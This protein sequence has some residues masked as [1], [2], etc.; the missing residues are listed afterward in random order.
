MAVNVPILQEE[1]NRISKKIIEMCKPEKIIMFGSLA[2]GNAEEYSDIDLAVVMDTDL[3][4]V[5]RIL[6]LVELTD[7]QVPVDFMVYTPK[8]FQQ[9][10][11]E[12]NL[13][14][15]EEVLKK[16]VILYDRNFS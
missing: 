4:F 2:A 5:E 12:D 11:E 13:F 7:P 14:L 3:R 10:I 1:L 6:H 15:T 16:G 9:M 8:E